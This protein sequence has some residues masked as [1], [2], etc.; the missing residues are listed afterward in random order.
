MIVNS[1]ILVMGVVDICVCFP[2]TLLHVSVCDREGMSVCLCVVW[3][4]V[5]GAEGAR[6]R[7]KVSA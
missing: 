4:C 6:G 5:S 2:V 1:V 7:S 3:L